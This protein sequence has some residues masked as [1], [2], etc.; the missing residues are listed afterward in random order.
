M[1]EELETIERNHTWKPVKLLSNTKAI[2]VK[3]ICKLK[4]NPDGSI[5]NHMARLVARRF[6]QRTCIEYLEVY[7]LVARLETIR[8]VVALACKKSWLTYHFHVKSSSLNEPLYEEVYVTQ[9]PGFMREGKEKMMYIL[10]KAL[11]GLK[12]APMA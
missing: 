6:M 4:H 12:Q 7:S 9:T 3:W 11:Y 1:V 10:N 2:E 5:A 8:L